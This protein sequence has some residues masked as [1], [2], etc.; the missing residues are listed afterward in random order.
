MYYQVALQNQGL[1]LF[2]IRKIARK[3][4]ALLFPSF[5]QASFFQHRRKSV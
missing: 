1:K 2:I 4:L 3:E 5:Y